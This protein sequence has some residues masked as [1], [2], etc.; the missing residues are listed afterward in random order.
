MVIQQLFGEISLP[1]I[2]TSVPMISLPPQN[3]AVLCSARL[4]WLLTMGVRAGLG[5]RRQGRGSAG[6]A[7]EPA[8]ALH[9]ELRPGIPARLRREE[10][11]WIVGSQLVAPPSA[12]E[13]R[14]LLHRPQGEWGRRRP[15]RCEL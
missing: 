12:V 1:E 13:H 10:R 2:R 9:C 3:T 7:G 5:E 4:M 11:G 15:P 14:Y 8:R 6:R